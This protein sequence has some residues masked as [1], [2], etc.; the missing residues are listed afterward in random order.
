MLR[1]MAEQIA[2]PRGKSLQDALEI[3]RAFMAEE[4]RNRDA[5]RQSNE[6]TA[7]IIRE[8]KADRPKAEWLGNDKVHG[9]PLRGGAPRLGKR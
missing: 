8:R 6:K 9:P 1:Y 7:S 3:A 2:A 4:A 5:Q